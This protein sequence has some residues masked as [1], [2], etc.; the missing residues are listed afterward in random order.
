MCFSI[1]HS[2]ISVQ[3][4]YKEEMEWSGSTLIHRE[5]NLIEISL[6]GT[7]SLPSESVCD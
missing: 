4:T 2:G 5:Q 6:W 1:N 3:I 7:G